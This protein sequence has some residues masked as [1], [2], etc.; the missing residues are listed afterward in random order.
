MRAWLATMVVGTVCIHTV[1]E[2]VCNALRGEAS[3]IEEPM[4]SMAVMA[5][6]FYFGSK[7]TQ[8]KAPSPPQ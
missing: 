6:G 3:M 7:S 2:T 5:L 4:Y 8:S 1:T